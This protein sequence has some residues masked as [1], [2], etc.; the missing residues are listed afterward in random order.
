MERSK[1]TVIVGILMMITGLYLDS[2]FKVILYIMRPP[3]APGL[4][5]VATPGLTF[6]FPLGFAIVLAGFII[7]RGQIM[8]GRRF[9]IL[10]LLSFLLV[11]IAIPLWT[12]V[13]L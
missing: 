11:I 4:I 13:S 2:L 1:S 5:I 8:N 7:H 10:Y 6:I 12:S 3:L 9:A